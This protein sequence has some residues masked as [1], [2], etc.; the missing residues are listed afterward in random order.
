MGIEIN[1]ELL[2]YLLLIKLLESLQVSKYAMQSRDNL[3][4]KYF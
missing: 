4:S 2:S 3:S 1:D